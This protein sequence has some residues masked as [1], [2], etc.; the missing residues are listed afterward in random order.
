MVGSFV[1]SVAS[2]QCRVRSEFNMA[3]GGGCALS[4]LDLLRMSTMTVSLYRMYFYRENIAAIVR[5]S[6][7]PPCRRH[8]DTGNPAVTAHASFIRYAPAGK[9]VQSSWE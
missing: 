1:W 4:E 8:S 6:L 7:R 5:W 2:S 9:L 3:P